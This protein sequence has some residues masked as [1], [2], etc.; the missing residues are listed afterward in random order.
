MSFKKKTYSCS[1][2]Q[3]LNLL[4][5]LS[6]VV[7]L[8]VVF[9]PSSATSQSTTSRNRVRQA[10]V[11]RR[12][13]PLVGT[14]T[15]STNNSTNDNSEKDIP[16]E[17]VS[18]ENEERQL[19]KPQ[20]NGRKTFLVINRFKKTINKDTICESFEKWVSKIVE[21]IF[22]FESEITNKL[23]TIFALS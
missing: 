15:S 9:V 12:Q 2:P 20:T 3:G 18:D 4:F 23:L 10:L 16:E 17:I 8:V 7:L 1:S 6:V 5:C 11:V 13:R 14:D 19:A 22:F 21:I